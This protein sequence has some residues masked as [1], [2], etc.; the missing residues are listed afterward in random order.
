M[1]LDLNNGEMATI[2]E[3]INQLKVSAQR[4]QKSGKTPRIQEV[5]RE[6]ETYLKKI[7]TKLLS[8]PEDKS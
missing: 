4:A 8:I 5:Y 6:H 7:E 2:L 1:K 3:G